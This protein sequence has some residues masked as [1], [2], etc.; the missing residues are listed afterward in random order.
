MYC[1]KCGN[2]DQEE[3]TYCRRCGEYLPDFEDPGRRRKI[4]TP[5]EQF[6]LSLV[7]NL[8]SSIAGISMAIALIIVF[9]GNA[10]THPVIY[11]AISLFFVISAWQ[12]VS[13]FNNLRLR[14]RF[15]RKNSDEEKE[16]GTL[17]V[18]KRETHELL[19]E[20]DF[21][22]FVPASV[23]ENTTRT[24]KQPLRNSTKSEQETD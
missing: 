4:Q 3:N 13:F 14:K 24:L 1:P 17:D 12:T 22:G 10:D 23:T 19:P 8:L 5:A 21:S 6:R 15:V 16:A 11:S 18:G 7:F 20:A 9:G 2:G